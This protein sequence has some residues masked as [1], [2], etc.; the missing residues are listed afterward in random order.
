MAI[1]NAAA[2]GWS[3]VERGS[4]EGA[5]LLEIRDPSG[6][7]VASGVHPDRHFDPSAILK[8]ADLEGGPLLVSPCGAVTNPHAAQSWRDVTCLECH[9]HRTPWERSA[10][11]VAAARR[12]MR[13]RRPVR[14]GAD[15][16]FAQFLR[17]L[18]FRKCL[19][20]DCP[21]PT[22]ARGSDGSRHGYCPDCLETMGDRKSV[23]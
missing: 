4:R 12:E 18:G 11:E 9:F 2:A 6:R 19:T 13:A 10:G 16:P 3:V 20:D 23:V 5:T 7:P 1:L 21:N 14:I 8:G 15:S 22:D 17:S